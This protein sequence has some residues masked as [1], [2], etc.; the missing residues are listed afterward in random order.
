MRAGG[1]SEIRFLHLVTVT[2]ALALLAKPKPGG[3]VKGEVLPSPV[4][5]QITARAAKGEPQ[6]D[7]AKDTGVPITTVAKVV[8]DDRADAKRPAPRP[9]APPT[10]DE[11]KQ[12]HK[13]AAVAYKAIGPAL[14]KNDPETA[15]R[16]VA[17]TVHTLNRLAVLL[18][19]YADSE[20]KS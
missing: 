17:A 18:G 12:L 13:D 2:D 1:K 11:L 6:R 20:E 19:R 14:T 16:A 5:Q 15:G 4:Q 10:L 3:A 8:A 9:V 7:I